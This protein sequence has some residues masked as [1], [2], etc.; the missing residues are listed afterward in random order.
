[1]QTCNF[2]VCVFSLLQIQ[3]LS[4][5]MTFYRVFAFVSQNFLT[6]YYVCLL[7]FFVWYNFLTFFN[8]STLT[9]LFGAFGVQAIL[10]QNWRRRIVCAHCRGGNLLLARGDFTDRMRSEG[11]PNKSTQ[12]KT[13][14]L[15]WQEKRRQVLGWRK[16]KRN[17]KNNHTYPTSYK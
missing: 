2:C 3:F 10:S 17:N 4:S 14:K 5:H 16:R 15:K 12:L 7:T 13:T 6:C 8:L 11:C 1:M 9:S